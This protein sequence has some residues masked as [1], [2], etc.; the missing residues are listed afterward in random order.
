MSGLAGNNHSSAGP[1]TRT[2]P[3]IA[4][5]VAPGIT[6]GVVTEIATLADAVPPLAE[7]T[8]KGQR[9][10]MLAGLVLAVCVALY[11]FSSILLPF[12]AAAC[13]AYF[14]D[15][16]TTRLARLGMPRGAAAG[17]MIVALLAVMLLFALLLY[18]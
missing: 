1:A 5:G 7:R 6:P 3:D 14:L 18:P 16:P 12:V 4:A 10:G 13:I 11:L 9:L 15:P 17:I 8:T 2:R